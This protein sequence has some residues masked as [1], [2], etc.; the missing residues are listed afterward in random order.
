MKRQGVTVGV[1]LEK[2]TM[3]QVQAETERIRK[4]LTAE[5]EKK[6]QTAEAKAIRA[7]LSEIAR[8]E[9]QLEKAA[10]QRKIDGGK[11]TIKHD[12]IVTPVSKADRGTKT[13]DTAY[14]KLTEQQKADISRIA[15]EYV[16]E[17]QA[18]MRKNGRDIKFSD[19]GA[20]YAKMTDTMKEMQAQIR[21]LMTKANNTENATQ[22]R[23]LQKAVDEI[24]NANKRMRYTIKG[25]SSNVSPVN[26]MQQS[27]F[28]KSDDAY[29]R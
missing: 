4:Q 14:T 23:K 10:V 8:L 9:K 20:A 12:T 21:E 7:R 1:D 25:V 27:H 22:I 3:R 6:A 11:T 5:Y 16:R 15:R 17:A 18:Q 19:P 2:A 24:K 13:K 29:R 26:A 28:K